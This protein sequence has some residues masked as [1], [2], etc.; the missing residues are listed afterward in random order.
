MRPLSNS[1]F[2][3]PIRVD[4]PDPGGSLMSAV[5]RI[6]CSKLAAVPSTKETIRA[7]IREAALLHAPATWAET[8]STL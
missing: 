6:S 5:R 3:D 1:V 7:L 2:T 4:G 8:M